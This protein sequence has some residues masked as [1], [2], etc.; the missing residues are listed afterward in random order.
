MHCRIIKSIRWG[1]SFGAAW[2]DSNAMNAKPFRPDMAAFVIGF[3]LGLRRK[4]YRIYLAAA[5]VVVDS[6]D[7]TE[8]AK[9]VR[10]HTRIY[11]RLCMPHIERFHYKYTN[12]LFSLCMPFICHISCIDFSVYICYCGSSYFKIYECLP[13]LSIFH[14]MCSALYI[15]R[16]DIYTRKA[17][18]PLNVTAAIGRVNRLSYIKRMNALRRIKVSPT[19]IQR[20]Q[21]NLRFQTK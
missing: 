21:R 4:Y 8:P 6:I 11:I 9:S 13:E 10:T 19:K 5:V 16:A 17:F 14:Q 1:Y 12:V 15:D 2:E 18:P 3:L 7:V 20:N